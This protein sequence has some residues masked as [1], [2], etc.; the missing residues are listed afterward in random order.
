[1]KNL[2]L[3]MML[4]LIRIASATCWEMHLKNKA[5]QNVSLNPVIK[6]R[7]CCRY[8][9]FLMVLIGSFEICMILP[10]DFFPEMRLFPSLLVCMNCFKEASPSI[11][12][13]NSPNAKSYDSASPHSSGDVKLNRSSGKLT[14]QLT[15]TQRR[16]VCSEVLQ[17]V[18]LFDFILNFI[19]YWMLRKRSA[20]FLTLENFSKSYFR[21][22]PNYS[23]SK[24]PEILEVIILRNST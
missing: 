23:K 5:K 4:L 8:L 24:I 12:R 21:K 2:D 19:V 11:K 13:Q 3:S 22:C 10:Y 15:L 7:V 17:K 6:I 18:S 14:R 20:H 1:M 16:Q 9:R